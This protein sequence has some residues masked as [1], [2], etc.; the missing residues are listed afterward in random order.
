MKTESRY[1]RYLCRAAAAV[2]LA[3]AS[4][5]AQAQEDPGWYIG[6]QA[7]LSQL[8]DSTDS[9]TTSSSN[10]GTLT[11]PS[12]LLGILFPN[13]LPPLTPAIIP[14]VCGSPLGALC[15]G[16]GTTTTG[17]N[18]SNSAPAGFTYKR[19]FAVGGNMGYSYANGF[20]PEVDLSYAKSDLKSFTIA[21]TTDPNPNGQIKALRLFLNGWYDFKFSETLKP[22]VG[23]G[24]GAQRS[25]LQLFDRTFKTTAFAYQLGAGFN[26]WFTPKTTLSLDYRFVDS[27]PDHDLG[28]GNKLETKLQANQIG[29]GLKYFFKG[30][31]TADAAP[32]ETAPVQVVEAPPPPAIVDSDGDGVP[33]DQDRCPNTPKGQ[34]VGPDGCPLDSDGDGIPDDQDECPNSPA[35]AKVLPNGC[36]LKGD[37]RRPKAG[38]P[39]DVNGCALNKNFILK[40]VKFE[41][42]SDRLT[43]ESKV[44]L[45]DVA[46]TLK[47]YSDITVEVAGH[48]DDIGTDAY[49]LGLSERRAIA[50]KTYLEGRGA[51]GKR[52]T[53]V[54]YG[55]T[56]PI[57]SNQTDEGRENNRR[58]EFKAE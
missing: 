12:G 30:E 31:S 17:S 13:T 9:V 8:R 34:K 4:F 18:G 47:S 25:E 26:W 39:V 53:P 48:T 19:G 23:V 51:D 2:T 46:E 41:F 43:A 33:D 50:V 11:L 29:L 3:T 37:C 56:T 36:A 5:M 10:S 27:R 1:S 54:G 6:G 22:Y 38:E 35:G 21:Q 20:R 44:I 7:F 28:N 15:S 57:D 32:A 40:G 16:G 14:P 58:V 45:N 42:D 49:N 55:K 52:L 24:L